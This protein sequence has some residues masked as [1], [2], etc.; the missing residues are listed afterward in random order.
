MIPGFA[1][2]YGTRGEGDQRC[3]DQGK[4]DVLVN[5][6]RVNIRVWLPVVL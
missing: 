5:T 2:F 1:E 6:P 3:A 4:R